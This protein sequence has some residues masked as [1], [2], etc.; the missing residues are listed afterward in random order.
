MGSF[1]ISP[2]KKTEVKNACK[3]RHFFGFFDFGS[4]C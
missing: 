3:F 2:L 4:I 1:G